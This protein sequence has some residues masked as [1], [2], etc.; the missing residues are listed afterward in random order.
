[1]CP[2]LQGMQNETCHCLY[3]P[4]AACQMKSPS[5]WPAC[6]SW[7][8]VQSGD[9]SSV[10]HMHAHTL[11]GPHWAPLPREPSLIHTGTKWEKMP[12]SSML[13][14]LLLLPECPEACY[15]RS[16][17]YSLDFL[18]KVGSNSSL[19]LLATFRSPDPRE[20]CYAVLASLAVSSGKAPAVK[21]GS[22]AWLYGFNLICF[23]Y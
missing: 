8:W 9:Y 3:L 17:S 18:L 2:A 16:V 1:M 4:P 21:R 5:G 7:A 12:K 19:L 13:K 23:T 11:Y 10:T 22:T 14:P 15:I 20:R 6:T